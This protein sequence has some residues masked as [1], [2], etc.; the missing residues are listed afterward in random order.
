MRIK[1]SKVA[2]DLN[3]GVGTVAEFLRKHDIDVDNNP[4]SRIDE[5]AVELLTREFSGDKA[6]KIISDT[7]TN[8]R[9]EGKKKNPA[10]EAPTAVPGLRVLGK[11]DLDAQ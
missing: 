11:I 9:R 3:V 7:R 5:S 6:D 1:I 10:D 4:N 2:K 8:S